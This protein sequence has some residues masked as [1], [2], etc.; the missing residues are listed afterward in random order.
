MKIFER[1]G[2]ISVFNRPRIKPS[3]D[4]ERAGVGRLAINMTIGNRIAPQHLLDP[5]DIKLGRSDQDLAVLPPGLRITIVDADQ[6]AGAPMVTGP[7]TMSAGGGIDN[8]LIDLKAQCARRWQGS[9]DLWLMDAGR[10]ADNYLGN[11]L[12]PQDKR[13]IFWLEGIRP[14]ASGTLMLGTAGS[15]LFTSGAVPLA[16]FAIPL[17]LGI[18][19]SIPTSRWAKRLIPNPNNRSFWKAVARFVL[20]KIPLALGSAISFLF[21]PSCTVAGLI[22]TCLGFAGG[23]AVARGYKVIR[24]LK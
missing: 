2:R 11:R 19:G 4:I 8:P 3:M 15:L 9:K 7:K 13:R 21:S 22:L 10:T 17:G 14:L 20:G 12:L 1:I 6:M 24:A 16:I 18:V 5:F 23:S